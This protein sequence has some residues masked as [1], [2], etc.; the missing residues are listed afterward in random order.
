MVLAALPR[1][2]SAMTKRWG[3]DAAR[4]VLLLCKPLWTR[5]AMSP[6]ANIDT[7]FRPAGTLDR[8]TRRASTPALR[9]SL[10]AYERLGSQTTISF[11]RRK[12]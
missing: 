11:S 1:L 6:S 4:A 7:C 12:K 8:R 2:R 5:F 10:R 9:S 3:A